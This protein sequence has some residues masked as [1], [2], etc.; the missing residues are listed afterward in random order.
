MRVLDPRRGYPLTAL[1]DE[2]SARVLDAAV[3]SLIKLRCPMHDGD[4]LAE[5]HVLVTL[6]A[7]AKKRVPQVV[8]DARDEQH[9]VG[10]RLSARLELASNRRPSRLTQKQEVADRSRLNAHWP[11]SPG[12]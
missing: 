9:V 11:R 5:L 7:Q 4:S 10:D 2:C 8:G 3:D 6:V 12:A 1:T